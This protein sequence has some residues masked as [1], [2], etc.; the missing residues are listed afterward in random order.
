MPVLHIAYVFF[1]FA[2][3]ENEFDIF[4]GWPLND[5]WSSAVILFFRP[6]LV[7]VSVRCVSWQDTMCKIVKCVLYGRKENL[8]VNGIDVIIYHIIN[9]HRRFT[10]HQQQQTKTSLFISLSNQLLIHHSMYD[11]N[12]FFL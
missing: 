1:H 6:Y 7:I 11:S 9:K 8:N 5:E 12:R 3:E 10:I 4:D 2:S